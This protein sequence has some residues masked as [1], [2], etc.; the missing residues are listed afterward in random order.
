MKKTSKG[1]G[2]RYAMLPG[3]VLAAATMALAADTPSA[4]NWSVAAT[5]GGENNVTVTSGGSAV[6]VEFAAQNE[7]PTALR[8]DLL[9]GGSDPSG[10]FNGDLAGR[11]YS[12]IRFSINGTGSQPADARVLLRKRVSEDPLRY[13]DWRYTTVTVSPTPSEWTITDVPLTRSAGWATTTRGDEPTLDALWAD[14]LTDVHAMF[15]R[16][17]SG[18]LVAQA[19]S[20]SDFRLLGEGLISAPANLSPLKH[21]FGVDS[22]EDLTVEELAALM[23]KDTD[24]DGMSD[25]HEILAGFDPFNAES[26]F[27]ARVAVG[28]GLNT[29]EWEGV[30]GKTYAVWRSNNLTAGFIAIAEGIKCNSTGPM[31]YPDDDPV[32]GA[33]NFYKV[34]NY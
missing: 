22:L 5:V 10:T 3:I 12:G 19:Y 21:Y 17:Q 31:T 13:R 11:G 6:T 1:T 16:I 29:I 30:L 27:A 32:P 28:P 26:V 9:V 33:P 7:P 23:A 2:L 8:S 20:V 18:G 14:D 24:K 25:Y 34:V 15:V 4:S